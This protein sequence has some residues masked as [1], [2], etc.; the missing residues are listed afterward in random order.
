MRRVTILFLSTIFIWSCANDDYQYQDLTE[1]D[2]LESELIAL[3]GSLNALSFPEASDYQ[4]IPAD[5]KNII[6][7]E[8]IELGKFLFH[9]TGLAK[10]PKKEEGLNTYSCASC[11]QAKAGFQSGIKQGIGEGG[12]GFGLFGEGRT[13]NSSYTN[14]EL[15]I[16]PIRSPSILNVAYQDVM[17]WNGQF[18]GVK[19]NEGTQ[20]A[21]TSGTPKATNELGFEGVETQAIA[22]LGVHR[23]TCTP[24]MIQAS[25]YKA[26]FDAAFPEIP[27]SE[28]YTDKYAG[29]AIAVYERSVLPNEPP[30][31]LLLNGNKNALETTEI[32]GARLFYGKANCYACHSGPGMNDMSFHALGMNDLEGEAVFMEVDEATKRG[33]GGFTNRPED[34]YKF[35]VPT[36]YNLKDVHFL[37][38]GG[39]FTNVKEVVEYKNKAEIENKAINRNNLSPLFVPLGLTVEEVNQLTSFIENG[40][41]DPN[42]QRYE[43]EA[44]PTGNCFPDADVQA[45]NDMNC[46]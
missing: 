13:K 3:Y 45:K 46:G 32:K 21:W 40:L 43:P 18:G 6:T 39:S 29:L 36:L 5:V 33:R 38:H 44:L 23:L 15:D 16:Q 28:R 30:F 17:L 25:A 7:P 1:S 41:Y 31:Q 4:S 35:K 20:E 24:E 26:L 11:H 42:L 8:K 2:L 12:S 34:D 27:Q 9:E 22:G 19:T 14:L 10:N 37:G